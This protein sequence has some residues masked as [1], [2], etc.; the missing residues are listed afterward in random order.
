MQELLAQRDAHI[1]GAAA[2]IEAARRLSDMTDEVVRVLARAASSPLGGHWA[3]VALGGWGA[4]AL[5][6]KS[7]LDIL[8]LSEAGEPELKTFAEAVLYPL[9]DAGLA[10]GHQVRSPKQQLRAMRE[11]VKTATAALTARPIA[12]DVDWA[13]QAIESWMRDA[14][15][16]AKRLLVEITA[17]NRPGSPFALEPDLKEDRGGRRDYD[18][19]TWTAVALSGRRAGDPSAL[20][21]LGLLDATALQEVNA[22]AVAI[23]EARWELQRAGFGNRLAI[24]AG[25]LLEER[26]EAA[27]RAMGIT[28]LTLDGVR[29]AS[30]SRKPATV[31]SA[32]LRSDELFALLD[33][34]T[35]ALPD[36]EDAAQAGSLEALLPGYRALMSCRRPGLG[37]ELTVGA[38]QLKAACLLAE[39]P[40]TDGAL[41]RS[42]E[43][44]S[45]DQLH[46]AHLAALVHDTGKLEGG[47]GHAERGAEPA[48]EAALRFGMSELQAADVA[49][50]VRLHLALAEAALRDDLDDEDTILRCAARVGRL[51]LLPA[52]HLL[53]AADARATGPSTWTPWTAALVGTLVARLDAA[54]SPDEDGAGLVRRAEEVRA[55]TL[56]A[57][58]RAGDA[59]RA[60]VRGASLR[61]LATREPSEI[62]RDA[63]LVAELSRDPAAIAHLAIS[64]GPVPETHTITIVAADKPAVFAR[65]AGAVSLAGLQILSVDAFEATSA[66]VLDC[67]VV[68]SATRRSVTTET[69]AL[70]ERLVRAALKDRLEL[71]TRLAE[72]RKH[73]PPRARGKSRV[74]IHQSGWATELRVTAPDRP[75]VLHDIARAVADSDLSI[76]WAKAA[77][78]DGMARD[79]FHL[80]AEDGSPASDK[81]VLGH[82]A[83]RVRS[84]L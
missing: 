15:K 64:A 27:Q 1:A 29:A 45:R 67:F 4:G 20:V 9:W 74:E 52:L 22:A 47:A 5:L 10:V 61:Y 75:G 42:L 66:A 71:Q 25:S 80:V 39:A 58:D 72:R 16:R 38:H 44:L 21:E 56:S 70:L 68:E 48:R 3:L 19:L 62:V 84:A 32:S 82:V 77:T 13:T 30:Q 54:L 57:M 36:L 63:S 18:E 28:A 46:T 83:M 50:L 26:A 40:D 43:S 37:H 7:D 76:S 78:I 65:L 81:G 73:Y 31:T 69:F 2:G 53:T 6:P 24:D 34:G 11:D 51:E 49:D 35:A 12:G 14:R 41:V 23:S 55:A 79:V 60:F 8:V 59:E 33:R 17:R